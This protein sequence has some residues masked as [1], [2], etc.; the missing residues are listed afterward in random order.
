[1][2]YTNL[3]GTFPTLVDGNLVITDVSDSPLLVVIGTAAKGEAETLY[4]P[5]TTS[6]VVSNFGRS[7][8]TLV[9]GFFEVLASGATNVRLMRVGATSA[10]VTTIGTGITVE[11]LEKDDSAGNNYSM[12]WDDT[13]KRLRIWRVSDDTLVYDNYPS[14]P[15]GAIDEHEISVT[16]SYSSTPGNIG[17]LSVPLL[18]SQTNA[19]SG[20]VYTAGTDGLQLSRMKIFEAL[21]KAY[22]LLE[23]EDIDIVL[24]QNVYLDDSNVCDMT[25]AEVSALNV[26]APWAASSVYPTAGSFYDALGKV[27]VQEY[28]GEYCFWWDLDNDGIAEVYPSVGAATASLDAY[29]VGL[30]SADFNE[31]NFGYQLADFC[32]RQ[33]EN[34]VMVRGGI[35][36]LPP[37][38]WSLKDVANWIGREP[39][40]S[41]DSEGNLI[42][43]TNGTGLYGIKWMAG[44]KAVGGTGLLGHTID[45]MN[46]LLY[47]GFIATDTG[48]PTGVQ[49]KDENDHLVDI[50]KYLAV[51]GGQSILSN[52]TSNVSY[53][54]SSVS[55]VTGFWSSLAGNSAMTNKQIPATRLPFNITIS[56]LDTLA[57]YRYIMLQ[58]KKK[59]IVISDAPSAARPD[60][61]YTRLSTV[62][63]I[64]G[65]VEGLRSTAEPFLGEGASGARMA[66]LEGALDQTLVKFQ[67]NQ[68]LCRYD[69]S[70]TQTKVDKIQG[71][72]KVNLVLVPAFEIRQIFI[73][74]ALAAE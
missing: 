71:K 26:T 65:V 70:V 66:A 40:S 57:G 61:D 6:Q 48:W 21:Y 73:T 8:G 2:A 51:V 25:T 12:F 45:G 11:T 58:S 60:S 39:V 49:L 17:T 24:P 52:P 72:I 69:M 28:N 30:S 62:T 15:T 37:E 9:R 34:S 1:M 67:K 47:G 74:L 35:G 50:G 56:K 19:V 44:R 14:Y 31:A 33:S 41:E 10:K 64:C 7:D 38:S 13:A 68:W 46:G 4:R 53:S 42:I 63:I 43:T 20:A 29:G 54:A 18:L 32:Y 5:I 23:N 55:S 59:G 22:A 16:G 36:V 3:P 27:F